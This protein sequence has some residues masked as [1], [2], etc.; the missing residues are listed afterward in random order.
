MNGIKPTRGRKPKS[1]SDIVEVAQEVAQEAAQEVSKEVVKEVANE[2]INEVQE[3]PGKKQRRGRRMPRSV[4]EKI[5]IDLDKAIAMLQPLIKNQRR[6]T[7]EAAAS[8]GIFPST[9]KA[10]SKS[11]EVILKEIR[12]GLRVRTRNP[13]NGGARQT[14]EFNVFVRETMQDMKEKGIVFESTKQRMKE[15]GRLWKLRK[16]Q[17]AL[18]A[19]NS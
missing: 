1:T 2:E 19:K 5:V 8:A 16:E 12:I 18:K 14:S 3:E 9:P 13:S 15:C 6:A 17:N 11:V 10:I 7:V 4:R